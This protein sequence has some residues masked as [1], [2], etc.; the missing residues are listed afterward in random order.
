MVCDFSFILLWMSRQ[1]NLASSATRPPRSRPPCRRCRSQ[2]R[3]ARSAFPASCAWIR[4]SRHTS[5]WCDCSRQTKMMGLPKK[6]CSRGLR[7]TPLK[8][9]AGFSILTTADGLL[10]CTGAG[11]PISMAF[12][13]SSL[14]MNALSLHWT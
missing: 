6:S 8:R 4:R 7:S 10:R 13:I 11:E 3:P 14:A 9:V 12:C 1:S 5:M 2:S